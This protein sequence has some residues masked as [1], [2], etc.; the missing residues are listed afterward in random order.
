MSVIDLQSEHHDTYFN[1]LEDW[2]GEMAEAGEH[3]AC[4]YHKYKE[5]G[6]RVKLYLD[7]DDKVAGMIQYLPIEESFVDGEELY[8]ILCIWVHSYKEGIGERQGRGIGT[9]LLKAAEEDARELGARGMAAWGVGLPFWMKASWFKK[10]GYKKADRDFISLLLWKPFPDD[11]GDV[12]DSKSPKWVKQKKS[13]PTIEGKVSVTAFINGWCPAQN[14][15][16]ER[17][18]QVCAEYGDKVIFQSIDTSRRDNF[19]EWGIVD[20]IFIDGKRLSY[21]PPLSIE[22]I[23]K[24]IAKR[25][26]RLPHP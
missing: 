2:S 9:A 5:R 24:K 23:R 15:V 11:A 18:R 20:G 25:V 3:K 22:K 16:Y 4:W 8:F 13:V 10:H 19:E 12:D 14:I 26:K 1:C 7:D 6:L 17:T 21:G